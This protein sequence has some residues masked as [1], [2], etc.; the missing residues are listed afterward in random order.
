MFD[1]MIER[2][3]KKKENRMKRGKRK[4]N[5][6]PNDCTVRYTSVIEKNYRVGRITS[7]L[8]FHATKQGK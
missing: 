4:T 6:L 5:K 2:K 3:K 8:N 7:I 1:Y